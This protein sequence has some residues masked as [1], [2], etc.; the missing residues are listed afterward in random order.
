MSVQDSNRRRRDAAC[1]REGSCVA[2]NGGQSLEGFRK[3]FASID[4]DGLAERGL[5]VVDLNDY[6]SNRASRG[7]NKLLH[8]F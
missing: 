2:R 7:A 4:D 6:V 8:K 3:T 5:G 1:W